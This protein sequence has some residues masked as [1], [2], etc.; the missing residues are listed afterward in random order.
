[1]TAKRIS[2]RDLRNTPSRVFERLADGEPL[3]LVADGEARALLL[4]VQDDDVS[5]VLEAWKRGR[6]L[7]ALS[8]LQADA[9]APGSKVMS[10]SDI[11]REVSRARTE[12]RARE[13]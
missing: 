3:A 11:S 8:R 1:M 4:P 10:M 2:Y 5:T 13:K 9:R 7:L 6:A 12:R